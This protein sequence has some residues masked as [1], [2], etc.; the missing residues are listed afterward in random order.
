[1]PLP[2]GCMKSSIS[3]DF[4][5]IMAPVSVMHHNCKLQDLRVDR[6]SD[7][8]NVVSLHTQWPLSAVSIFVNFCTNFLQFLH[9][10]LHNFRSWKTAARVRSSG[11]K[12]IS[13][14]IDTLILSQKYL[15]FWGFL[16]FCLP[17]MGI[18]VSFAYHPDGTFFFLL[19][20]ILYG[21]CITLD[22]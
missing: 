20:S 13:P 10:K 22:L 18:N 8:K 2:Y 5:R 11:F 17:C 4:C 3:Y 19:Y 12:Y 6:D 7:F 14:F 9:V 21:F 15:V 16:V 1:M